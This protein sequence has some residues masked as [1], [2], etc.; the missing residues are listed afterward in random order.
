MFKNI[1][2]NIIGK[3]H[4]KLDSLF[5]TPKNEKDVPQFQV[6]KSNEIQQA[7][8]LFITEDHGYKYIL[9]VVDDHSR[10]MDAEKLKDKN[11]SS[12]LK[13]FKKIYSIGTSKFGVSGIWGCPEFV[14]SASGF[15]FH[16]IFI[17]F[18]IQ[19]QLFQTHVNPTAGIVN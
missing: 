7:D 17:I 12:V 6:F 5:K 1:L 16:T 15:Q 14:S 9:V 3:D 11:S 4:E 18:S 8:L 13:A 10:K 2:N 19:H